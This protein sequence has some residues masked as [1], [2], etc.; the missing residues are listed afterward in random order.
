MPL[1]G[2]VFQWRDDGW[3]RELSGSQHDDEFAG[4]FEPPGDEWVEWTGTLYHQSRAQSSVVTTGWRLVYDELPRD[5]SARVVLADA[6]EPPIVAVGGLWMSEWVGGGLP[7][8]VT[9]GS[10]SW[11]L[12]PSRAN[13]N[14]DAEPGSQGW[15]GFAR[16]D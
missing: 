16:G 8:T 7:A 1:S 12:R 6:T 14:S 4:R 2:W 5:C 15:V 9:V 3:W 13:F 11:T 10:D